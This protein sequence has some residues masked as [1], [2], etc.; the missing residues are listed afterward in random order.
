MRERL[1]V[2]LARLGLPSLNADVWDERILEDIV[3]TEEQMIHESCGVDGYATAQASNEFPIREPRIAIGKI[4][5][6]VYKRVLDTPD[7]DTLAPENVPQYLLLLNTNQEAFNRWV[8]HFRNDFGIPTMKRT[9][10][11]TKTIWTWLLGHTDALWHLLAFLPYPELE[12]KQWPLADIIEWGSKEPIE[13]K[14]AH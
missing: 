1:D 6:E 10:T 4:I 11:E 14:S 12:V 8:T 3:H 2:V 7:L 9:Q 13:N 5:E